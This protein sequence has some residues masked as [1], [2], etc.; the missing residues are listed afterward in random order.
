MVL[1]R[2]WIAHLTTNQKVTG[3]NP[4]RITFLEITG[5]PKRPGF[6]ADRQ[7]S[8]SNSTCLPVKYEKFIP[9]ISAGNIRYIVLLRR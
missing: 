7:I 9:A 5:F 4:V 6:A 3:S 1:W 8:P 2:N